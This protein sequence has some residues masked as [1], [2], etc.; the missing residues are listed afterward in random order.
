MR[1][2]VERGGSDLHIKVG[3][4]A[5]ARITATWARSSR[6]R[7]SPP[8]TPSAPSRR[9][10]TR[11]PSERIRRRRRG[12]L[13]L[14]DPRRRALPRQRLPPARFG[15]DRLPRDSLRGPQRSPS[16]GCREAVRKLAESQRGIVLA[17]RHHRLRQEHDP[18]GDDRPHQRATGRVT[19]SPSRTRSSTCT[20]TRRS[21]VNQREIGA[22]TESF[23]AGD[24]ARPAPGPRRDPDRRDARRG[25]GPHGALRRRDRPPRALD[26]PHPRRDRRRSTASSTSSRPTCSSRRRVMLAAT[27]ARGDLPAPG[28]R[29]S[30]ARAAC[31]SPRCWSSPAASRT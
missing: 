28:A 16:S 3:S 9:S 30:T 31:R 6:D 5:A 21:I 29:R 22:D 14:R 19:S 27:L 20:A 13:R 2:L 15:L 10:P 23:A 25:D 11:K 17:D 26:P 4:P 12:R 7:R 8:R 18:G 24:A 1:T